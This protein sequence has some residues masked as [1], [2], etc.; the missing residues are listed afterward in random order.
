MRSRIGAVDAHVGR[1]IRA[2]R[3]EKGCDQKTLV[4]AL[5]LS[6][7]QLLKYETGIDRIGA[8]RLYAIAQS[9]G[10]PISYFYAG[11]GLSADDP[12]SSSN[13]EKLIAKECAGIAVALAQVREP[14]LRS[15][16]ARLV[17]AVIVDIAKSGWK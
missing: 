14:I 1:R 6:K 2:A 3:Y 15:Q 11:L 17:E 10:M 13:A 5:G 9:L 16:I 7:Q 4:T 12:Q 8:G